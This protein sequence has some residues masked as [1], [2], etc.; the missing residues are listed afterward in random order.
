MFQL[1]F[2]AESVRFA[3]DHSQSST[4]FNLN[5]KW[6]LQ[7]LLYNLLKILKHV[8][9]NMNMCEQQKAGTRKAFGNI[10]ATHVIFLLKTKLCK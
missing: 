10:L 3:N 1:C 7:K 2:N 4:K 9:L 5:D 6:R 8:Y